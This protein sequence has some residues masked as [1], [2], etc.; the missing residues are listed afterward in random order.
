MFIRV[1]VGSLRCA[2]WSSRSF[3]FAW[4]HS[5]APCCHR[6][7]S[8]SREFSKGRLEVVGLRSFVFTGVHSG[9]PKC[10]SSVAIGFAFVHSGAQSVCQVDSVSLGFTWALLRLAVYIRVPLGR[11]KGSPGSFGLAWDHS[12]NSRG[13]FRVGSPYVSPGSLQRS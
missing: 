12:G 13:R 9:V 2:L 3:G 11:A 8:V 4:V 7:H 10:V 6:V 1:R 5:G